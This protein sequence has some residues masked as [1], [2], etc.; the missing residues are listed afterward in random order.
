MINALGAS[1]TPMA[2]AEVYTGTA[3]GV[4]DGAENNEVS[5]F[6]AEALRGRAVLLV[7]QSPRSVPT[8]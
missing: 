5:Y 3:V 7:H 4:I 8:S 1:P 2:F 6:T